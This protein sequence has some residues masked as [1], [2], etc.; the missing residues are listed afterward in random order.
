MGKPPDVNLDRDVAGLLGVRWCECGK[1]R[2]TW[3]STFMCDKCGTENGRNVHPRNIS[4]YDPS[5]VM[6]LI[7]W[8]EKNASPFGI[9]F[10][11]KVWNV[12]EPSDCEHVRTIASAD[13]L[14]LALAH[15]ALR[16]QK[17]GAER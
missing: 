15:A 11:G 4:V 5:I 8:M 3:R 13:S 9:D 14:P 16:R 2:P 12:V 10:A 1:M 7:G 17:K 6:K